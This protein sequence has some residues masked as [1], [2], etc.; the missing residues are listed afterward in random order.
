MVAVLRFKVNRFWF[1]K[2]RHSDKTE[3]EY[4]VR[5]MVYKLFVLTPKTPDI[6]NSD[7]NEEVPSRNERMLNEW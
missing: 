5:F 1:W 4:W 3:I 6:R 2:T 7:K